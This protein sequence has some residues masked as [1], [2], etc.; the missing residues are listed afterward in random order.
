MMADDHNNERFE[1]S[2]HLE[3]VDRQIRIRQM[4]EELA[5]LTGGQT[6]FGGAEDMSSEL[7]E[8]FLEYVLEF[9]RAPITSIYDVL[10]EEGF[11][12]PP[13][14]ELADPELERKL[15]ELIARL[16]A[17]R[18][19]LYS[20]DHLSDRELYAHLV[21]DVLREPTVLPNSPDAACH[22]DLASSGSEEDIALWLTFYASEDD[23]R[24]WA[25]DFPNDPI[26]PHRT[27][28]F[29]RDRFLPRPEW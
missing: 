19:Y 18:I 14:G 8:A 5:E 11:N 21:D 23:R 2:A 6:L 24:E 13:V 22:I 26:P 3:N 15:R 16:G 4:K 20:T 7:E 28:P 1:L 9:E 12:L 29:D 25:A 10:A 27:P 17:M